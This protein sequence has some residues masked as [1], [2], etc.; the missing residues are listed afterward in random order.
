MQAGLPGNVGERVTFAMLRFSS[1]KYSP[2]A[3][4]TVKDVI[5]YSEKCSCLRVTVT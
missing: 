2:V 1:V 3:T 5:S 4:V